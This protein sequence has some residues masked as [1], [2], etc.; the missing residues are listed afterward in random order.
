MHHIHI[1]MLYFLQY[2]ELYI[3]IFAS[4]KHPFKKCESLTEK[5]TK[6]FTNQGEIMLRLYY[7]YSNTWTYIPFLHS[8]QKTSS[9]IIM[10]HFDLGLSDLTNI[11]DETCGHTA[12]EDDLDDKCLD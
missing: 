3:D 9:R 7:V 6:T 4:I 8:D 2:L 11:L 12:N 10:F 1:K 5:N